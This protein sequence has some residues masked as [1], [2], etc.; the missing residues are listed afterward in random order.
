MHFCLLRVPLNKGCSL[1]SAPVRASIKHA[2]SWGWRHAPAMGQTVT[3]ATG[4][5]AN[6]GALPEPCPDGRQPM[7][8]GMGAAFTLAA[9]STMVA[10]PPQ[11]G[12]TDDSA[13]ETATILAGLADGGIEVEGDHSS[14]RWGAALDKK[15]PVIAPGFHLSTQ[16]ERTMNFHARVRASTSSVDLHTPSLVPVSERPRYDDRGSRPTRS[17][18]RT[19]SGGAEPL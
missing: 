8:I 14:P 19:S 3:H 6:T 7:G 1:S 18:G 13:E 10:T 9:L 12:M 2:S 16:V 15:R 11:E 17:V 4:A 5:Q